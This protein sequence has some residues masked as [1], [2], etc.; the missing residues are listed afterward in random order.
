VSI[1]VPAHLAAA[2]ESAERHPIVRVQ[3]DW[4]DD[5]FGPEGSIDDL[6]GKQGAV[7][8]TRQLTTDLPDA[9]RLTEGSAA[10]TA[11][12]ELVAGDLFDTSMHAARYFTRGTDS[13]IGHLERINRPVRIDIGFMT[14][15]GPLY[16]RRMTGR[17]RNLPS[18]SRSRTAQLSILDNRAR[19]RTPVQLIPTDGSRSGANGTWVVFQVLT[20]NGV[21][22]GPVPGPGLL[23]W[24]PCYGSVQPW[25]PAGESPT[26]ISVF[27]GNWDT[28][29]LALPTFVPGPF[30]L[31][32]DAFYRSETDLM[33]PTIFKDVVL[34]PGQTWS[35]RGETRFEVWTYG[36][37]S[38]SPSPVLFPSA[39]RVFVQYSDIELNNGKV[40]LGVRDSGLLFCD[41]FDSDFTT[42]IDSVTST[43]TV[44]GDAGWHAV[45]VHADLAAGRVT[46]RV[47]DDEQTRTAGTRLKLPGIAGNWA[48]TPDLADLDITG[49]ID[50]RVDVAPT[51]WTPAATQ[52]FLSK[53][54][55]SGHRSFL[56]QVT[57]LGQLEFVW[58]ASGSAAAGFVDSSVAIPDDLFPVPHRCV[59]RVTL[60]VDNGAAGND[61]IFY[62]GPTLDGPWR[63]LGTT[64]TNAGVTSIFSGDL[65][66]EIGSHSLGTLTP[67]A[68]YVYAAQL[69]PGINAVPV[70]SPHFDSQTPGTVS[71]TDPAGRVWTV[72]GSIA[73]IVSEFDLAAVP[74]VPTM[75]RAG[76]WVPSSDLFVH[77]CP[78]DTTWRSQDVLV[79]A[80]LDRSR[81]DLV[82]VAEPLPLDPQQLMTDLAM[83]EQATAVWDEN[84]IFRYRTR[85]RLVTGDGLIA[86]RALT[87]ADASL[88]DVNIDDGIDQVRNIVQVT[89]TPM[90]PVSQTISVLIDDTLRTLPPGGTA[91]VVSFTDLVV[92]LESRAFP[93]SVT[94]W[95]FFGPGGTSSPPV[96]L[97]AYLAITIYS[98]GSSDA[99]DPAG[100]L[101]AGYIDNVTCTVAQWN[102]GA[103]LVVVT[104]TAAVTL[105]IA[106]LSLHGR[107]VQ[108]GNQLM[109]EVRDQL[110]I[111]THGPQGLQITLPN[112]VQTAG[113][114][115]S[116]ALTL[117]GDLAQ[118]R[119]S[120]TGL[121][122]VG[123]P[124]RQLGDRVALADPDG[125]QLQGE[126][127]L[128]SIDDDVSGSGA[129]VQAVSARAASSVLRW[130]EGRWGLETWG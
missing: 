32:A 102:A 65:P 3:V 82:A 90:N 41:L 8:I 116:L 58:S 43:L 122:I 73:A 69:H 95:G 25:M 109:V 55:A 16:V 26:F 23:M 31:A 39:G 70:A 22:C 53:W 86:Q 104:N 123:D 114:A 115:Q 13:P 57:S 105:Y 59:V 106:H 110:S 4:E 121:R 74:V 19:L 47:D 27:V 64:V 6:T 62:T 44:P 68:G 46:F 15:Q 1:I 20:A 128:T 66:V 67:L 113:I 108:Q 21:R 29:A 51:T 91:Y 103:A 35:G 94:E 28:L 34:Q 107:S 125:T 42:V 14:E 80:V 71:F 63:Q 61:T 33:E 130:G 48:S 38:P 9:V 30:V 126:F 111:D 49:D 124:R 112:W 100:V 84:G 50:I 93:L 36:A 99:S 97:E 85:D 12:V 10:A 11:T 40:V 2:I 89:Y 98:D 101:A 81:L 56:F 96:D 60:D 17:T 120:V 78:A 127:W 37:A 45:G 76:W 118:A 117:L 79:E 18:S 87:T 83:S 24:V 92:S 75:I 119:P 129:Y 7:K 72:N 5:G 52:V 88:L 54:G 77:S